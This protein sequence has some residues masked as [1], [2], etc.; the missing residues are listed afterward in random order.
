VGI[1]VA[2]AAAPVVAVAPFVDEVRT[3][4]ANLGPGLGDMLVQRLS[5]AGLFVVPPAALQAWL[6][7]NGLLPTRDTWQAAARV[8]GAEF[9]ILPAVERFQATTMAF[10]LFLFTVR[11][12]TVVTD[13]RAEV[14]RL[15]TGASETVGA[16]GEASGPASV[17][18]AVYFPFDVCLG[19][20]RT[21]KSVYF[22]GETVTIGYRDPLPPNSFYVVI[23]PAAS[24]T[25][26]WTSAV[27]ASTVATPCVTWAWNQVFPPAAGPGDYVAELYR[28]PLL[29]PIVTRPFT[30]GAAA[31]VE[32]VVGSP[33]F[34]TAPWGEALNQALDGLLT[35]L[36]PILR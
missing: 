23:R 12:A 29:T 33:A 13:L 34:G 30:I 20:F 1:A 4:L 31:A 36:L 21:D 16:R 15:A 5:A 17:E 28:I 9:L 26:S 3:G 25:P 11:G 19:G 27:A 22:G 10:T 35:K 24:L 6:T 7:Q 32:L 18:V 8:F 2:G 14:I